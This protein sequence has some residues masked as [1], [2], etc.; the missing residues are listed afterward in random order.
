VINT[1][2]GGALGQQ[3]A[4]NYPS[5][6][7]TALVNAYPAQAGMYQSQGGM[8]AAQSY[9]SS[10]RNS[11][12]EATIVGDAFPP[13]TS[14]DLEHDA[15]KTPV[16]TLLALWLARFGNDWID[17][18]KIDDDEFFS[19]AYRRLKS[20]GELEVHYLTDRARYVCRKPE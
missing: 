15:Y 5:Q 11:G 19:M 2:F 18:E 16:A 12:R 7:P 13:A 14:M 17:L 3:S 20:M 4:Q 8:N 6:G 1:L 9:G 10:M